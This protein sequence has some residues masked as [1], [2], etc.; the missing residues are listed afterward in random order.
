MD[1][2]VGDA[3][4]EVDHRGDPST[5][6]DLPSKAV[7]FGS[8][9]QERGQTGQ[10]CGSQPAGSTG[11]GAVPEGLRPP[12]AGMRHPLA[13]SPLADA[14]GCGDLPLGPALLQKVP[15]LKAS[16]FLPIFG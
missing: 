6:P 1:S 9:V 2:M 15:G 7:G 16:G 5:G 14:E 11:A 10:L 8:T 3:K 13:N 4:F 12:L